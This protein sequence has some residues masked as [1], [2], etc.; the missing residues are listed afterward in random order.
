VRCPRPP[1]G[2]RGHGTRALP[3]FPPAHRP[4][5]PFSR[6]V[7]RLMHG[8]AAGPPRLEG[9]VPQ[10]AGRH[11]RG[12]RRQIPRHV[13]AEHDAP[14]RFPVRSRGRRRPGPLN[15]PPYDRKASR[16]RQGVHHF[17]QPVQ[18]LQPRFGPTQFKVRRGR[19]GSPDLPVRGAGCAFPARPTL[20]DRPRGHRPSGT[21]FAS[22]IE[23]PQASDHDSAEPRPQP[24]R[25]ARFLTRARHGHTH[26]RARGR[27][28]RWHGTSGSN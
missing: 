2:C 24:P 13:V 4:L 21:L 14:P 19:R 16:C 25:L 9:R 26:T 6:L 11:G 12:A 1:G 15:H 17:S 8:E 5:N 3:I 7:T 18:R 23:P 27:S 22:F 10:S 28:C 20:P